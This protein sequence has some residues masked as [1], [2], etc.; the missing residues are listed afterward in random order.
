MNLSLMV[1]GLRLPLH[2]NK[3]DMLRKGSLSLSPIAISSFI[4][5]NLACTTQTV[6][7]AHK[8]V[9]AAQGIPDGHNLSEPKCDVEGV[10]AYKSEA[11]VKQ[12]ATVKHDLCER[13]PTGCLLLRKKF[14]ISFE[15]NL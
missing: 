1:E 2:F 8:R 11:K 9:S 7:V 13:R 3:F 10:P 15:V 5:L 14:S 4:L 12:A 6:S